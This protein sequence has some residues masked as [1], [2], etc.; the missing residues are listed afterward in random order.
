MSELKKSVKPLVKCPKCGG[1][2]KKIWRGKDKEYYAIKCLS[3]YHEHLKSPK[4]W[5][6]HKNSGKTNLGMVFIM[7][8]ER[9]LNERK[10]SL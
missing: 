7:R 9:G 3:R 2:G 10:R 5:E 6:Y 1:P 8:N 4:K